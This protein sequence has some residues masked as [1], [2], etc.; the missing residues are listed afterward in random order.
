MKK[1]DNVL[2]DENTAEHIPA[3]EPPTFFKVRRIIFLCFGLSF[4][5]IGGL[6]VYNVGWGAFIAALLP[7][8]LGFFCI[9][10]VFSPYEKNKKGGLLGRPG[11]FSRKANVGCL[12]ILIPSIC[13][14][15]WIGYANYS[16]MRN[17]EIEDVTRA[18]LHSVITA[19][20]NYWTN[21]PAGICR[22]PASTKEQLAWGLNP[23]QVEIHIIDGRERSFKATAKHH[24]S[25]TIFQI[26]NKG[27]ID[28]NEPE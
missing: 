4:I 26:D 9:V 10:E 3:D 28:T 21:D 27:D 11:T 2:G 6:V 16:A 8:I 1:Q 7:L 17:R 5:G 25:D 22:L 24:E 18:N 12:V 13:I 20:Y 23:E 15:I 19:C 14:F